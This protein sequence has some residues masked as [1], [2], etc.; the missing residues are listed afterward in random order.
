MGYQR[1]RVRAHRF[2]QGIFWDAGDATDVNTVAVS[3][4]DGDSDDNGTK[5][6]VSGD[7][8]GNVTLYKFPCL[9]K[10]PAY[11]R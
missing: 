4:S 3:G 6:I 1:S 8:S 7:D 2:L 9:A 5:F 10:S 11:K